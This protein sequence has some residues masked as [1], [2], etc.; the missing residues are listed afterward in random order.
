MSFVRWPFPQSLPLPL[1]LS[2]VRDVFPLPFSLACLLL[3]RSPCCALNPRP[4]PF[5]FCLPLFRIVVEFVEN[6]RLVGGNQ[7][8]NLKMW[9]T[10]ETFVGKE[11]D[12]FVERQGAPDVGIGASSLY[13]IVALFRD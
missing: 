2:L 13:R 12:H 6:I 7:F 9:I 8:L 10:L 11:F 3:C 4:L 1:A 5:P